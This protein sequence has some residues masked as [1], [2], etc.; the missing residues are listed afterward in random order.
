MPTQFPTPHQNATIAATGCVLAASLASA[1]F[2]VDARFLFLATGLWALAILMIP[3]VVTGKS[4]V[5]SMWSFV[6][7][8]VVI[9]VTLRGACLTFGFPDD[10]RLDHLFY[11]GREPA[12]FFMPAG[13]LL[14]GLLMLALGYLAFPIKPRHWRWGPV[15]QSRALAIGLILLAISLAATVLYIAKTGGFASGEWSAKRTVIP[16]LDL[17]GSGYQSF[18]GLR[19]LGSLAIFGHL[20]ILPLALTSP[21]RRNRV[22]LWMLAMTLLTVACVIPF[23]A[24]LRTTVAMH[25]LLFAAMLHLVGRPNHRVIL[26]A[27]AAVMLVSVYIMTALRPSSPDRETRLETPTLTRIFEAAVINRNQID[28][29]KTAHILEAIPEELPYQHGKT[30]ARWS[31]APIPRSLWSDK[32]VI[33]PGPEIGRTVY[34][35]NVAGVPPGLIAELFWNFHLTG[36]VIGAF[37]FGVLLRFLQSRFSPG[38]CPWAAALF[39]A[40]PMTLGFEAVGSSIGSGLFRAALHTAV[41][42]GLLWLIRC[43]K[44]GE[45]N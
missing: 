8:T 12:F 40:G 3:V 22:L 13:W 41:M 34:G 23:Y 15:R 6:A 4:Q 17:K 35:Q 33:P 10:D 21:T 14:L 25:L 2:L 24:S 27:A 45:L 11:L 38:D 36:I 28:L 32:P 20:L 29:P 19:F 16:D 30:I 44:R 37:A 39:V 43:P 1:A 42:F 9:G 31:L 7:L 5:F 18:G 26:L